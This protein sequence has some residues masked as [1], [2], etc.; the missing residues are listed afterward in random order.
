MRV[1]ASLFVV[2]LLAA[3]ARAEIIDQIAAGVDNEV[4]TRSEVLE[5]IRVAAFLNGEKPRR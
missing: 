3:A 5:Q 4:I 2:L 1:L